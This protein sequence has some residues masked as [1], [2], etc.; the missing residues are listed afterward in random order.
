MSDNIAVAP[1]HPNKFKLAEQVSKRWVAVAPACTKRTDLLMPT[2]WA[3]VAA[4]LAPWDEIEVRSEDGSWAGLYVVRNRDRTWARVHEMNFTNFNS[5]K[6]AEAELKKIREEYDVKLRGPKGWSVVRRNG[7]TVLQENMHSKEDADV[8]LD[9][10][11][12]SK[13]VAAV[14]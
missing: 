1:I 14:A 11:L 10:F 12:E 4:N 7:N 13:N 6:L 2:Y 5:P 8:W 9:K 3:H